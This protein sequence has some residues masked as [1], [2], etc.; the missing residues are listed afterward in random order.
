MPHP[1]VI[2][3]SH[4]A[5][6]HLGLAVRRPREAEALLTALGYRMGEAV[7]DPGQ[8][9]HLKMCLHETEP[10]VEIIWP[11]DTPGPLDG[12][13]QRHSSGIIYHICYVTD[14]LAAALAGLEKAG[15]RVV[16]VSPQ[17][18]APLFGGRPVSFYNVVG[19]GLIE[20]LE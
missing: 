9:V 16:C 3:G 14:N 12:M 5:F 18:P 19:I 20:I 17:K 8:N 10:D 13:M 7:L 2:P 6:H 4:L 1:D 11:G 15:L